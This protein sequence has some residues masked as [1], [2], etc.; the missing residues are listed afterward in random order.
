MKRHKAQYATNS[1]AFMAEARYWR[2]L[3]DENKAKAWE[4]QAEM[5][6]QYE[7]ETK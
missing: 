3:G 1:E 6:R 5:E 2:N 4:R 7:E